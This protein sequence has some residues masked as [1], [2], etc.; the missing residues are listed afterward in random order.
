MKGW[1]LDR[2]SAVLVILF[3][4]VLGIWVHIFY[5]IWTKYRDRK[6]AKDVYISHPFQVTRQGPAV[7]VYTKGQ[8]PQA[9]LLSPQIMQSIQENS[10][11]EKQDR[12]QLVFG[13]SMKVDDSEL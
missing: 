6:V 5:K 8:A 9:V 11:A 10:D 4:S 2:N 1:I 13:R 3:L 12:P 7:T